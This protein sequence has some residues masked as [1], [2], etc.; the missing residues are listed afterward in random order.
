MDTTDAHSLFDELARTP[1]H[2][3][4][5]Y[6]F[7]SVAQVLTQVAATFA[8]PEEAFRE[9]PFLIGYQEELARRGAA[10][11]APAWW[12]QAIVAWERSAPAFL[13]LRALREAA[14]LDHR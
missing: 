2:H 12:H 9:F 11:R 14:A 3:F 7:A 5:L 1:A 4:R 10:D 8:T 13:P 6:Y